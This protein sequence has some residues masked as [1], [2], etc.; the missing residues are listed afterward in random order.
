MNERSRRDSSHTDLR[1]AHITG[2]SLATGTGSSAY[3]VNAT[4]GEVLA[5]LT[6][7]IEDLRERLDA[8]ATDPRHTVLSAQLDGTVTAIE[9]ELEAPQPDRPKVGALLRGLLS[10]SSD[11][12]TVAPAVV[13]LVE[14]IRT[15]LGL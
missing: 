5:S 8:L 4:D 6:E 15:H 1:G 11:T 14:A 3:V 9:R 2:S 10:M 7:L 12:A 13:V